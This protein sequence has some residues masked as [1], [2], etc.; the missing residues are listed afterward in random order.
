MTKSILYG[1]TGSQLVDAKVMRLPGRSRYV[2]IVLTWVTW[3]WYEEMRGFFSDGSMDFFLT[4]LFMLYIYLFYFIYL[5]ILFYFIYF[6]LIYLFYFILF[7]FI[8]FI[9]IYLFIYLSISYFL[10]IGKT[11]HTHMFFLGVWR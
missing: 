5:F 8:L 6:I 10:F 1:P 7:Y 2:Q 9:F 4:Y 11:I 3:R